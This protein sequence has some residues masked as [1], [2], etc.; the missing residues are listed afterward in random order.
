ML[1]HLLR[2][3]PGER[4]HAR[5]V[6]LDRDLLGTGVLEQFARARSSHASAA[7]RAAQAGECS[8]SLPNFLIGY[9]DHQS[10]GAGGIGFVPLSPLGNRT[11]GNAE[12]PCDLGIAQTERAQRLHDRQPVGHP[13]MGGVR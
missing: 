6:R 13:V 5:L 11:A 7:A 10:R 9:A 8:C 2:F 1:G 3:Q 4:L 12:H